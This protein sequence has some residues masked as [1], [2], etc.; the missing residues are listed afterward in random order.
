MF[1]ARLTVPGRYTRGLFYV[2]RFSF[3]VSLVG[4]RLLYGDVYGSS[5]LK[6]HPCCTLSDDEPITVILLIIGES[7]SRCIASHSAVA[8]NISASPAAPPSSL[9][10]TGTMPRSNLVKPL[11]RL[12]QTGFPPPSYLSSLRDV[13][14]ALLQNEVPP[15]D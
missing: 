11:P 7:R 15:S 9:P 10:V 1:P 5:M 12:H 4:F 8:G 2:H 6:L 13:D 3:V 14:H